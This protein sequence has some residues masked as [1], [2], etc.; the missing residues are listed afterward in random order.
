MDKNYRAIAVTLRLR[1]VARV[2]YVLQLSCYKYYMTHSVRDNQLP[3]H[4]YQTLFLFMF[5]YT[6]ITVTAVVQ[7]VTSQP[8]LTRLSSVEQACPG[9]TILF[10]CTTTGSSTLAWS[11]ED[12]IGSD[13]QLQFRSID[14]NGTVEN[15][16]F[17][18]ETIATLTAVNNTDGP[19][20]MSILRIIARSTTPNISIS[21]ITAD[22]GTSTLTISLAGK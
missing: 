15:S 6:S 22:G 9:S 2:N 8:M 1:F 4:N 7:V 3:Y 13:R 21:C 16:A 18:P 17:N 11:S 20:L 14:D 10:A 12:Y 5:T 19:I